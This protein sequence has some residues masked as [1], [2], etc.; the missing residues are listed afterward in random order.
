MT[1]LVIVNRLVKTILYL[2]LIRPQSLM[3]MLLGNDTISCIMS[4]SYYVTVCMSQ[5]TLKKFTMEL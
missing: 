4:M 2:I 5:V 3:V 1:V